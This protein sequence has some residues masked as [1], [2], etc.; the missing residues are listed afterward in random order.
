MGGASVRKP[1][2]RIRWPVILAKDVV[3]RMSSTGGERAYE[4]LPP[5]RAQGPESL[6]GRDSGYG[7][8]V[9]KYQILDGSGANLDVRQ[10]FLLREDEK[11]FDASTKG[12]GTRKGGET[13][14]P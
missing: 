6:P 7:D 1:F 10:W 4:V 2:L 3:A 11:R 12:A 13:W 14:N 5:R 9:L 8:I